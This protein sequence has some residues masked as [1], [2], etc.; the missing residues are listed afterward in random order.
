M[1]WINLYISPAAPGLMV[2]ESEH[3]S[4]PL[5]LVVVKPPVVPPV[6][7]SAGLPAVTQCL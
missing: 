7:P 3:L 2:M 1:S 4:L 5:E 6:E